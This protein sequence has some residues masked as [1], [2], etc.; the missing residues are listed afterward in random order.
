[1]YILLTDQNTVQEIIPDE[2]P[3]F[4]GIPIEQRY[5]ADY[6]SQLI[7]VPDSTTVK[8]NWIYDPDTE[9]FSPPPE[10]EVLPEP[11]PDFVAE[12]APSEAEDIAALL[13]D[14]EYRLTLL[15]LGLAEGGD[16]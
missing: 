12:S 13:V 15:E 7:Y 3:A 1:M 9:G 14:H 5:V 8:Q 11:L 2:N 10:P 6:I 16:I 4:P